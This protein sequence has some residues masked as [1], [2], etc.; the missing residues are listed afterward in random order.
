MITT[1]LLG[2]LYTRFILFIINFFHL[3]LSNLYECFLKDVK[4]FESCILFVLLFTLIY[5]KFNFK[6]YNTYN[7]GERYDDFTKISL[8]E[9]KYSYQKNYFDLLVKDETFNDEQKKKY[10]FF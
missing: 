3:Y 6:K 2:F 5:L 9:L 1:P 4:I 10:F 8:N 7:T